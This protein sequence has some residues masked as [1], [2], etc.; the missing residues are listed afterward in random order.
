MRLRRTAKLTGAMVTAG[1]VGLAAASVVVGQRATPTEQN[2]VGR[3]GSEKSGPV[4]PDPEGGPAWTVRTYDSVSGGHCVELGRTIAGRFGRVDQNGAFQDVA[5]DQGGV[6]GDL[7]A[8]PAILAINEYPATGQRPAR[9]VLFGIL[10]AKVSAIAVKVPGGA[11]DARPV[12]GSEGG[13]VLPVAGAHA[14]AE[15]PVTLTLEDG[16]QIT[17]DWR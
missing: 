8:E 16:S 2:P 5:L 17:Y 10:G 1:V 11:P 3:P 12:R 15:L 6:C 9:T 4:A 14:P 13:V 7:G